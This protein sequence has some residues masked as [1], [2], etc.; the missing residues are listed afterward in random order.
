M[1]LPTSVFDYEVP[2][3]E[4]LHGTVEEVSRKAVDKETAKAIAADPQ[5]AYDKLDTKYKNTDAQRAF[6]SVYPHV[7][8][9]AGALGAKATNKIAAE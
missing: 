9:L 8:I 4:Q 1:V 6:R 3:L 7:G 5:A 2:I